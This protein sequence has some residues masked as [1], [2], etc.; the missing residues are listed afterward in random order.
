MYVVKYTSEFKAIAALLQHI[1]I[2]NTKG[3]T[4]MPNH[5]TNRLVIKGD[6]AKINEVLDFIKIEKKVIKMTFMVKAPS[7][8]IK[9][10]Q[11]QNGYSE[12]TSGQKKC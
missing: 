9:S 7:I 6:T 11:C 12:E 4:F 8:S 2:H 3:E 1:K 5:I 10:L